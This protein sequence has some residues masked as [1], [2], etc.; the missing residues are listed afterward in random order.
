MH[1]IRTYR[2]TEKAV[3]L[4]KGNLQ[5][6]AC[7]GSGKTEVVSRRIA[8]LVKSGAVPRSI[9]AFTFTEK[10]AEELKAKIREILDRECPSKADL[11]DMYV[12]RDC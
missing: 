12:G 10:A 1:V 8:E 11:G 2:D 6:I 7:A 9:V 4:L 5:I 3:N